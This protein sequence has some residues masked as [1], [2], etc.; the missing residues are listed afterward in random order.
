MITKKLEEYLQ[1]VFK[2]CGFDYE[3]KII[4]SNRPDLCDYQCDDAFKMAK[5]YKQS[6]MAISQ[7]IVDSITSDMFKNVESVNGF[8]NMTLS[9]KVINN[10]LNEK[11]TFKPLKSEF[12]FL[13][14]GGPNIA[15]PL[16][17][18]HLRTAI[19]GESVKRIIQFMG[20]KTIS[21]VHLGD[22]GLQ[23]G[24][25]IYGILEDKIDEN[26]I[27]LDYLNKTYPRISKLCKENDNV[28][29]VCSEI[30]KE[31]QAGNEKYQQLWNKIYDVSLKGIKDVYNYLDVS[32][33]LYNGEKNAYA[34]I[35]KVTEILENK[36]LLTQSEGALVVL[37]K[38][39]TDTK[40][41][42]PLIYQKSNGAYLYATTD[43][44]TIYERMTKYNPD[45]IIY[46]TDARQSLHFEQVFRASRLAG[47]TT[48]TDLKHLGY[49][50]VNGNDGKPFKT[51]NG[52]ALSLS[53]L[54]DK[55]KE[56]FI[57]TK[58]S[59]QNMAD[60][61]LNIITNAIVKFADLQNNWARDYIFDIGKFSEVVGKTG[62]YI[63]YT[64][65]RVN[66]IIK[67]YD[68]VSENFNDKIYNGDDRNLRLKLLEFP[69]VIN[70]AFENFM[71]SYLADY[72]YDICGLVNTFYQNNHLA[73]LDD[74]TIK[75]QWLNLLEQTNLLI[76]TILDLLVI[77]IPSKM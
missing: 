9:D 28:L 54:L 56:T 52:D 66:K 70:N 49:G 67:S 45:H 1:E 64:Y 41:I 31:L 23:M 35:P 34:Y 24:Q 50:T 2:E 68:Q 30:T 58:E 36:N 60:D 42:P 26:E 5:I 62:P 53:E 25:V 38:E 65:L 21:D 40:E 7:K 48:N 27:T 11:L 12:F 17:V 46:I 33:D 44:A 77:K 32:F 63:L 37:V 69:I 13:D 55:V 29:Q 6:P 61:D 8:I 75:N 43:M 10:T 18:G 47:L 76:K 74:I 71:P 20:H 4:K 57:K 73:S 14:Y 59:N 51:R 19:I 39:D 16:H 72:L 3:P 15:K 22:Y